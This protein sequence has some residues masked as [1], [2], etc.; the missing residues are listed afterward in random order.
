MSGHRPQL[1]TA[2]LA[3]LWLWVNW[4]IK[5]APVTVRQWAKRGKITSHG[6]RGTRGGCYDLQEVQ[7]YAL[8][9]QIVAH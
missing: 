1:A 6:R 9:T 3:A 8:K 5:I 2:E 4:E 7:D